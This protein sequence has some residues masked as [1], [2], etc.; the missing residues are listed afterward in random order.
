MQLNTLFT[1]SVKSKSNISIQRVWTRISAFNSKSFSVFLWRLR[2]NHTSIK[3]YQ[4]K[5]KEMFFST[6]DYTNT[7]GLEFHGVWVLLIWR[8][9][10]AIGLSEKQT[11]W[12]W[13][14]KQKR[15]V[16]IIQP[17]GFLTQHKNQTGVMQTP[18]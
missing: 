2:N 9:S 6:I 7:S 18:V 4:V 5:T 11:N 1:Y 3:I 12:P 14:T 13:Q 15:F 8:I 16:T 10:K 17:G